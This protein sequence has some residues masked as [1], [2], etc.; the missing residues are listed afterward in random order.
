MK[1]TFA[2]VT[3]LCSLFLVSCG[4][5]NV[6]QEENNI[7]APAPE[8]NEKADTDLPSE[9]EESASEDTAES[10][11]GETEVPEGPTEPTEPTEPTDPS[12]TETTITKDPYDCTYDGKDRIIKFGNIDILW[13]TAEE[14][15]ET[16]NSLT[17]EV[18]ID[19]S[20]SE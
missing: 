4:S 1:K 15:E 14:L 8:D 3:C 13:G 2:V 11:E 16:D 7:E 6:P 19:N 18:V 12:E 20:T 10:T 5:T 9:D 17:T